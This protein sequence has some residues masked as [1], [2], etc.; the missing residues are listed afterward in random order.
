MS[1]NPWD[2]PDLMAGGE[3]FTF[4]NDGDTV[5]GIINAIRAHRFTDGKTAPQLLLTLDDG[6]ERTVSGGAAQLKAELSKLRPN[7]GDHIQITQTGSEARGGGKTLKHWSVVVGPGRAQAPQAQQ[8]QQPQPQY[9]Q[10]PQQYQQPVY[11]QP[12]QQG[13]NFGAPPFTQPPQQQ[14]QQQQQGF[15]PQGQPGGPPF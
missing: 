8:W 15:P 13:V 5:S 10:P 3:F 11:V 2:D 7:V 1:V 6:S 14:Q 12:P 4:K 9:T